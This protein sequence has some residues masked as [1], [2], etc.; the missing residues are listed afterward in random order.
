MSEGKGYI[1]VY[2]RQPEQE[3]YPKGLAYSIHMSYSQ[4]KDAFYPMN[5]NYGILF[6]KAQI[7][8]D[9]TLFPQGVKE[10]KIFSME[11]G[12]FGIAAVRVNENG[13]ADKSSYGR[14]L[15]WKTKD[16]ITFEEA[17]W[18]TAEKLNQM[19]AGDCL[20]IDGSILERAKEYW[21]P[22][23]NTDILIPENTVVRSPEEL[24]QIKVKAV[25]SDGSLS[26]KVVTW[27]KDSI[28]FSVPGIYRVKGTIKEKKF[29]F[30]LAKGYGD[31]VL[32]FWEGKWY[33]TSTNDNQNDIGLYV[34][35]ADTVAGL[36]EEN[37]VEHL[38]LAQDED[39]EL[40]Q[41]FWAP[42]FHVIGGTLYLLFAVS[43]SVWGPQCHLMR[44]KDGYPI[45]SADSWENPIRVTKR[46]G[47]WLS[48]DGITLDMTY[49]KTKRQSYM[50]W[51]YRKGIGTPSDTGSMLYIA[52]VNEK[53]P[54]KLA[55]DPVLLSRPLY[56]W[57]NVDGT[58]N[59]EGPYA[60]VKNGTVYLTY[61]GGSANGY[62]YAL[63]LLTAQEDD[64]LLEESAWLKRC[65]PVLSFYSV[66]GEYG[67]GH[68]SFYVDEDGDLMIAYHGETELTGSLRCN[69]IRRVHFRRDGFPEF[70]M[71][72]AEDLNPNLVRVEIDVRV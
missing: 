18:I 53:E 57:E 60:F 38:I 19:H 24:D 7:C 59:N 43:G 52:A 25:Y 27:E 32:F 69:G 63:G 46:D 15:L 68:N 67:P 11:N 30:P 72:A 29:S 35:E 55:S 22:V 16:F 66:K 1:K 21:N 48:E 50:V 4:D 61:S 37:T 65:A 34:R 14:L 56:G 64:N 8:Q 3:C 62:T 39:R 36:F 42:E 17:G 54:W 47:S 40:I 9:N 45:T 41:T 71:A 58:I 23:A 6:A 51:S 5:R 70:G 12:G 49:L 2:T 26:E 13:D 44:L 28:N 20:E 10:P 31:P 33:Y